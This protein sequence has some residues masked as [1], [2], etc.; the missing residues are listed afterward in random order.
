LGCKERVHWGFLRN[1]SSIIIISV[2]DMGKGMGKDTATGISLG[3]KST[4][5]GNKI[6]ANRLRGYPV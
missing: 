6:I 5:R 1:S 4:N 2:M 3:R